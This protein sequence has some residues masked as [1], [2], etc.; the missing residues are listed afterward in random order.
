ME[1]RLKY[2]AKRLR[3]KENSFLLVAAIFIGVGTGGVFLFFKWAIEVLSKL[4]VGEGAEF[5]VSGYIALPYWQRIA[6]PIVGAFI[7]GFI[8]HFFS[9]ESGGAGLGTLLKALRQNHGIMSSKLII[10]KIITSAISIGTGLPLGPEG[11]V[12]TAGSV[13]GST[14]GRLFR[15]SVSKIKLLVGCGAAAGLSVAFNAPIAG[16]IFAIESILGHFAITSLTPIVVAATTASFFGYYFLPNHEVLPFEMLKATYGEHIVSTVQISSMTEIALYLFFG[17]INA[18]LGIALIKLTYFNSTVVDKFSKKLPSFV[19]IPIAILPI[20]VTMAFL[21]ALF[22]QGEDIMIASVN[23]LPYILIGIALLKLLLLSIALG[24]G[25]SGG[26]FFPILFVGFMFGMGFGKLVPMF[27][28]SLH[29]NM[30]F[31]FAAVGVGALLGAATQEP[32]SSIIMVFEITRDYNV[33]PPLMLA[34]VV[35]VAI[36]KKFSNFSIYNY[37]L[38]KEGFPLEENEEA[39]IMTENYVEVC[40]NSDCVTAFP[41]DNLVKIVDKMRETEHFECYVTDHD[42]RY[43]GAIN[44]ILT[45]PRE[46]KYSL[47]DPLIIARDLIDS[48]FPVVSPESPLA[49]AMKKMTKSK[50]IEIPVVSKDGIFMGAIHSHDIITFYEREIISK[51]S[52]INFVSNSEKKD[53]ASI[54]FEEEYAIEAVKSNNKMWGKNLF[55]LKLREQYNVLVLAV[56]FGDNNK[57]AIDPYREIQI[58]D[59]LI[60]AAKKEDI[61]K[62]REEFKLY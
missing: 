28:P 60:I 5:A 34:T 19:T 22:G 8:I 61:K 47:I 62:F 10:F 21:P 45:S 35:S 59:A 54:V 4:S 11:P 13:V 31:S 49:E 48:E 24:S 38:V 46:V 33:I 51:G 3:D 16:T 43:L 7:S 23:W 50:V 53:A 42:N 14:I 26:N 56:K 2:F 44:S 18:L 30:G 25:A 15:V 37:Q 40:Y 52:L 57:S 20:V 39:T 41:E 9:K 12:I 29:G 27:F 17:L 1:K 6:I 36:S 55:E 32:I 58:G